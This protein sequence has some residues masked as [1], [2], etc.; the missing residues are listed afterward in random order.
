[1][2][3]SANS[4]RLDTVEDEETIFVITAIKQTPLLKTK[5]MRG[6][7]LLRNPMDNTLITKVRGWNSQKC[8]SLNR[9]G[10]RKKHKNE[11]PPPPQ[12]GH[13]HQIGQ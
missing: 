7:S 13:R 12:L 8:Q 5:T 10:K 9:M 2:P 6:V 11:Q 3:Q 1:M 4:C